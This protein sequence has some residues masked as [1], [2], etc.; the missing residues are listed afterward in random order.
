MSNSP[1]TPGLTVTGSNGSPTKYPS[2]V[3]HASSHTARNVHQ[4]YPL[5]KTPPPSLAPALG[6]GVLLCFVG[7]LSATDKPVTV[8]SPESTLRPRVRREPTR[9][10]RLHKREL[11][12]LARQ[13]ETVRIPEQVTTKL[14]PIRWFT[15]DTYQ[16]DHTIRA[17]V[18]VEHRPHT[19]LKL[20][21][22]KQRMPLRFS[23][24]SFSTSG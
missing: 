11:D 9:L 2:A 14:T 21:G 4:G 19:R 10:P 13:P 8:H 17:V 16:A 24:L 23:Q 15:V 1:R 20:T 7:A 12:P 6:G 3:M 18:T 22:G 5:A